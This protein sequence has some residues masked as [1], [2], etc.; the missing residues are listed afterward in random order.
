MYVP[1][2]IMAGLA[3]TRH[4]PYCIIIY[5]TMGWLCTLLYCYI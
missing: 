4:Q 3:Q 2:V 5:T 1:I